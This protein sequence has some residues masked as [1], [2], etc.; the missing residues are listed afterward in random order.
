MLGTFSILYFIIYLVL[1]ILVTFMSA[2]FMFPFLGASLF[3]AVG[4]IVFAF[5]SDL[6][7]KI[8][9]LLYIKFDKKLRFFLEK[10]SISSTN[11]NTE[12][13]NK[14]TNN[15]K[16]S[17]NYEQSKAVNN[18]AV[19]ESTL[20]NENINFSKL[21]INSTKSNFSPTLNNTGTASE[22][23]KSLETHLNGKQ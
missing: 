10:M 7:Y 2:L 8:A 5:L 4:V 16:S 15:S 1:F 11:A 3:F 14:N 9:Y 17:K 6:T 23:A 19:V 21:E 13:K 22:I 18:Q 20:D 12:S